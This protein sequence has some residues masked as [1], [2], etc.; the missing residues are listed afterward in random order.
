MFRSGLLLKASR[1]VSRRRSHAH[2]WIEPNVQQS[3]LSAF[4]HLAGGLTEEQEEFRQVAEAFARKE[5]LPFAAKWDSTKHFPVE[6]L[7]AAAQLGFGGIFVGEDMGRCRIVSW[8][9]VC[10][11]CSTHG[12]SCKPEHIAT[13]NN[14]WCRRQHT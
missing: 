7:R 9:C 6:T 3:A 4:W 12:I 1:A 13:I 14:T 2:S 10:V 5:L 8:L 11:T